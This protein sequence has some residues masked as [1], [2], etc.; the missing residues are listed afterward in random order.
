MPEERVPA[1]RAAATAE[2][3]ERVA[4]LARPPERSEWPQ[5]PV[6][7][8]NRARVRPFERL[9]ALVPLPRYGSTDP[10]PWLAVFFPLFFGLVLGDVAFGALGV[11]VALVL[12][13]RGTGGVLGRDLDVDRARVRALRRRRSGSSTARRSASSARTSGCGPYSSI[14]AARSWRSSASP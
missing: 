2:L 10:T 3:G 5:V 12:R 4:L 1:L 6:V 11:V 13:V 8:R 14:A 7:L 9:L